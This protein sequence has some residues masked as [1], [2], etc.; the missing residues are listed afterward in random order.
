MQGQLIYLLIF[1]RQNFRDTLCGKSK[2]P[3]STTAKCNNTEQYTMTSIVEVRQAIHHFILATRHLWHEELILL[4]I[5]YCKPTSSRPP[6]YFQKA[7]SLHTIPGSSCLKFRTVSYAHLYYFYLWMN[8]Q[9]TNNRC[10]ALII[11]STC[12][13][14]Y[15]KCQI[16]N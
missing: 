12:P 2:S 6:S 15:F 5:A 10:F 8:C 3:S 9:G 16:F 4:L 14:L 1:L 13:A 11:I 7:E